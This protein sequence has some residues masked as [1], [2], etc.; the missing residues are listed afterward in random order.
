M[1]PDTETKMKFA[2][3]LMQLWNDG[4]SSN[5]NNSCAASDY[6]SQFSNF[7]QAIRKEI[8]AFEHISQKR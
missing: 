3:N 6:I 5:G 4:N 2:M 7:C 8:E 1:H